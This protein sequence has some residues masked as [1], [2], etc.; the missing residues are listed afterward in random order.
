MQTRSF[1]ALVAARLFTVLPDQAARHQR[2]VSRPAAGRTLFRRGAALRFLGFLALFAM[3]LLAGLTGMNNGCR[4]P[5][6][7]TVLSRAGFEKL[8]ASQPWQKWRRGRTG[9]T[10][11]RSAKRVDASRVQTQTARLMKTVHR[12][13]DP[14]GPK[15]VPPGLCALAVM[16][17]AP[18][19]GQV[20]TR[21]TPPLTPEEAAALNIC[22]L[23][24]TTAALSETVNAGG[25]RGIGVF[26]PAGAEEAF[27][28][29]LPRI[30]NS[31]CNAVMLLANA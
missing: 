18:R 28:E 25:A 5:G 9:D 21:L 23:R 19:A 16:T 15:Q 3:W 13:L 1:D 31:S 20:K 14:S 22:F 12:V 8:F 10:N 11:T 6:K 2:D 27:A 7:A 30:S 17:K 4:E 24:D 29:I 26:T